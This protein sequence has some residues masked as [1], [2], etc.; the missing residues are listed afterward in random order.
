MCVCV[1]LGGF[2]FTAPPPLQKEA[3][4]GQ[5]DL[6]LHLVG[7]V[8]STQ[9]AFNSGTSLALGSFF[10]WWLG[11]DNVFKKKK[12]LNLLFGFFLSIQKKV[13]PCVPDPD[14]WKYYF[15]F[16]VLC[17]FFVCFQVAGHCKI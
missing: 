9:S 15:F 8:S 11:S 14:N 5:L 16:I 13:V 6:W 17:F 4:N 1:S 12:N 10:S 2:F 3:R 7:I